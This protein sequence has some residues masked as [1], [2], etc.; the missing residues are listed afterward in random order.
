MSANRKRRVALAVMLATAA[1]LMTG[2]N[3]TLFYG[4]STA[5]DLAI[6]LN[7]NPQT[8]IEVNT[9]LKRHVGQ[10]T[11]PVATSEN[12]GKTAAVGEAVSTLSGF[13]LRYQEDETSVLLGDLYIRTQFATGAAAAAL[14]KNPIQAVKVMNADFD[15]DAGF[16]AA[17][18]Q[19]RVEHILA[20]IDALDDAEA[21]NLACDPSIP[22]M[23]TADMAAMRQNVCQ[24]PAN[25]ALGKDLLRRQATMD[26]R[27]EE[28][29]AAW[30]AALGL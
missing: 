27:S 30:E 10:V 11:P 18:T 20:G 22:H 23:E 1:T 12:E 28:R 7:D 4:E 15:R 14:A 16:V 6:H 13:R 26:E 24:N 29:L 25:T 9:G 3:N 5:F 19:D 8:P 21:F 2:C 17:E